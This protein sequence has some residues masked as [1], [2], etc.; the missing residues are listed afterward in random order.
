MVSDLNSI[1]D[2]PFERR[3]PFLKGQYLT[4]DKS[5]SVDTIVGGGKNTK[6]VTRY[7]KITKLDALDI[8]CEAMKEK[9]HINRAGVVLFK[10]I[11]NL[12]QEKMWFDEDDFALYIDMEDCQVSC[13]YTSMQS[14]W[15]G[16]AELLKNNIIARSGQI[17]TYFL[18]PNFFQK[19]D[20]LIVTEFFKVI[21]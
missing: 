16:L 11:Y 20:T 1:R 18:N 17:G 15:N 4:E 7:S 9:L 19:A 6:S 21:S 5:V 14:V 13:K 12:V 8:F 2:F 3:N 10:Y